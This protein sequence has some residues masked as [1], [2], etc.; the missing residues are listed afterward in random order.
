MDAAFEIVSTMFDKLGAYASYFMRGALESL[1]NMHK[2][3]DEDFPFRK[4]ATLL[5]GSLV[6]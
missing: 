3:I 6:K 2:L 4:Q 5:L 1:A